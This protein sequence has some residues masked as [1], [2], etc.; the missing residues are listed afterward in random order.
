ML[1]AR[2]R[3][4]EPHCHRQ[5]VQ[6]GEPA[7]AS[8]PAAGGPA[9][10]AVLRPRQCPAGPLRRRPPRRPCAPCAAA[11]WAAWCFL[12]PPPPAATGPRRSR[13]PPTW[14][15]LQKHDRNVGAAATGGFSCATA[16]R[17][18]TSRL[19]DSSLESGQHQLQ[20]SLRTNETANVHDNCTHSVR[21]QDAGCSKQ[22][23][24]AQQERRHSLSTGRS[25]AWQGEPQTCKEMVSTSAARCPN[26]CCH[27]SWQLQHQGCPTQAN[28]AHA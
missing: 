3:H 25:T 10:P 5:P 8:L 17:G 24:L 11:S 27:K 12:Q 2:R 23:H 19:W 21:L 13:T 18:R 14:R 15:S 9:P 22:P 4:R 7:A 28:I 1:P 20:A 26:D 6:P 16:A